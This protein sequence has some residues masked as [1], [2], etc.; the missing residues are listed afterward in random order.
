VD[1]D[2]PATEVDDARP[3][4]RWGLGDVIL[5]LVVGLVLSS[6]LAGLWLAVSGK[7]T[8]SIGGKAF[9]Q[10]GL[11]IGLVGSVVLATRRKGSGSLGTDFGW[12]FRWIDLALG[13]GVAIGAQVVIIPGVAFLLRPLL[14]RPNV[15]APVE[16]LINESHGAAIVGLF[17]VAAV[18]AP[19]VEELFFRGL[20]LRSIQKRLGT[21]WAIA[22]SSIF[23][24]LAHPNDLGLEA[25]LLVMA[26]LAALGVALATLAVKTGRLG[27]SMIAHSVFN[28]ISLIVALNT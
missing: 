25:Q 19:I 10:V 17:L 8:L 6:V 7:D 21:G 12:G 26:A 3:V 4:P 24:G 9:S 22:G 2:V 23:F 27:P 14:G 15:D 16:D 5:G 18:G 1:P 28:A 11:W 13:A 20:L